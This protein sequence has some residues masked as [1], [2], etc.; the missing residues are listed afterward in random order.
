MNRLP[1]QT[2]ITID[3]GTSSLRA[4]LYTEEGVCLHT[5]QFHYS[6]LFLGSNKVEQDPFSWDEA[7][8]HTLRGV[9]SYIADHSCNVHAISIASQRASVIP[10]DK[11]GKPLYRAI[12]WQDK[13][14]I[15]ESEDFA[16]ILSPRLVYTKTGLRV[17]SYFSAPKI[18]W[19]KNHEPAVF[20]AASVFLGV[21]DYVA[22]RLTGEL[23]TDTSQASRTLMMDLSSRCWDPQLLSVVGIDQ[24]QLPRIVEPSSIC[25]YLMDSFAVRVGLPTGIPVVL[26]GGDQG[27]AAMS[28]GMVDPGVVVANTGTGSFTL[29]YAKEPRFDEGM[30]SLCSAGTIPGSYFVEAG[31]IT[32][33]ILVQ[34]FVE[35]F[36]KDIP[37]EE[38]FDRL[39]EE[40]AQA[41]VGS[42][43]VV[44][45][46]HFKGVAAPFWN[47]KAKG[48][49]FN[50][51][52][53]TTRADM[54][55]AVLEGI[56]LD[57]AL[58]FELIKEVMGSCTRISIA[59]GMTRRDVFNQI[60]ADV[61]KHDVWIADSAEASSLGAWMSAVVAV[62]LYANHAK[63]Y[64]IVAAKHPRVF[65]PRQ[66]ATALYDAIQ[67]KRIGLYDVLSS[68]EIYE[69]FSEM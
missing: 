33:G 42:H 65:A 24:T 11:E 44:V 13:R 68:N 30:R 55:R 16:R 60:Q 40:L 66:E 54:A 52:L 10:L 57:M 9:S 62:G 26:A 7:L 51:T 25:G 3:V 8:E 37:R 41:P 46:P 67:R 56:S 29:G 63:A 32:S 35:Q 43:G 19:L 53:A 2:V 5:S 31:L 34:W 27:C 12:M 20:H 45:L 28:L 21:Q 61:Y 4:S 48:V 64:E 38:A 15:A 58:N 22:Y 59:G 6:P 49:F 1:A 14:S 69:Q 47:P 23:V 36:F 50:V 18:M 17:D 39:F